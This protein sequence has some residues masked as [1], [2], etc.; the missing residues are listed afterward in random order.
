MGGQTSRTSPTTADIEYLKQHTTY[1]KTT[2]TAWYRV[3]HR[4]CNKGKL[5]VKQFVNLFKTF[6]PGRNSD[7]FCE[8]VFRTF[9]TSRSGELSFR[10]FLIAIYVTSQGSQ[11]EKLRW[12]FRLYDINGDGI[13]T[14]EEVLEV[15]EASTDLRGGDQYRKFPEELFMD[16]DS[17]GIGGLTEGQFVDNCLKVGEEV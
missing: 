6:F 4:Q 13:L 17:D 1:D 8:H 14:F 3:F 12:T 10:E 9:N 2:I 7:Q 11:E 16:L 5:S 15:L